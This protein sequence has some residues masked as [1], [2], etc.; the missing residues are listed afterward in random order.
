[1]RRSSFIKQLLFIVI[2]ITIASSGGIHRDAGTRFFPFLK[3]EYDARAMAMAGVSAAMS[4]N[5]YGVL[6]NPAS[7]GFIDGME[8][9]ISYTPVVL[10]INGLSIAFGMPY[11]NYGIFAANIIY[12]SYGTF[13]TIDEFGNKIDGDLHPYSIAGTVAWSRWRTLHSDYQ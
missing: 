8:A 10:D 11:K 2:I 1:M 5:L 9:M 3:R 12:M 4:N 6:S 13:E 7:L